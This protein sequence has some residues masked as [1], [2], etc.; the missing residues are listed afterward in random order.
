MK[1][2]AE[3]ASSWSHVQAAS[4]TYSSLRSWMELPVLGAEVQGKLAGLANGLH[5]V[6]QALLK[7]ARETQDVTLFARPESMARQTVGQLHLRRTLAEVLG[8]VTAKAGGG[9]KDHP[10]VREFL[11]EL[12]ATVFD[13]PLEDR[14]RLATQ[15]AERLATLS[16]PLPDKEALAEQVRNAARLAGTAFESAEAAWASWTQERSEEV[17][18]KGQLRLELERVYGQLKTLFP[19]QRDL[20]ESFFPKAKATGG[21]EEPGPGSGPTP[22]P[23]G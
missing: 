15:A 18:V 17:V 23:V 2:Q 11:P 13:A 16:A 21:V 9:S 10:A 6:M 3:S 7:E 19:G 4:F 20:V 12:M 14:A 5:Q 8:V 1:Q 22:T